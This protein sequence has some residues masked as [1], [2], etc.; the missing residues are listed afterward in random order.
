MD[1]R[2]A[3]NVS[4]FIVQRNKFFGIG[5]VVSVSII[6]CHKVAHYSQVEFPVNWQ[7]V[8]IHAPHYGLFTAQYAVYLVYG[9]LWGHS[10]AGI[11]PATFFI[12]AEQNLE[13]AALIWFELVWQRGLF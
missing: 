13:I 11:R 9:L 8:A 4:V 6:S 5:A 7:Q 10:S 12:G 1:A 3:T 2:E